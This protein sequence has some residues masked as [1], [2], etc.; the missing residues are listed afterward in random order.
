MLAGYPPLEVREGI[1]AEGKRDA[2]GASNLAQ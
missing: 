1:G 2:W